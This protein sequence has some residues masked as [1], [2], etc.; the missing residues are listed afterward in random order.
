MGNELNKELMFDNIYY[1]LQ[2]SGMKIGELEMKAGVS[3]GYISRAAKDEKSKPG[4]DFIIGASS[5]LNTSVDTLIN[6]RLSELTSTEKYLINFLQ[7]LKQDTADDKLSWN[8]E[9][10]DELNRLETDY[11]GNTNHPLFSMETFYVD[12]MTDYP[13]EVT[14]TVMVSDTY[15]CNTYIGG[16]CFNLRMKNDAHLYIMNIRK[17]AG[18]THETNLMIIEIWL[19]MPGIKPSFLCGTAKST[20]LVDLVEDLY[21]VVAKFT[22]HPKIAADLRH[23]IDAFM[24]DVDLNDGPNHTFNGFDLWEV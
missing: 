11:N 9:S 14:S 5:A 3:P 10:A 2:A 20:P 16:D 17:G 8:K 13:D 4:I 19:D 12:G 15:G 1:L 23:V 22:K 18:R 6:I 24:Q 21:S 7:K